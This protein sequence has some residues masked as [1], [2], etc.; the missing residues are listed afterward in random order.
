MKFSALTKRIINDNKDSS[1]KIDPWAVHNLAVQ[2]VEKGD[3]VTIL[4]IG[5]ETNETT[6]E[7]IVEAAVTSLRSGRHHY[8]DV[9]G[10]ER[11]RAAVARYHARLTGQSMGADDVTI[12]VGAQNALFAVA[13]VLLGSDDEVILVAPFYT[14][15]EA[16]FGASG[17][18]VI[19]VQVESTD[20]YQLD[21]D[22]LIAAVTPNTQAI[23]LNAP[24][25]PLGS[26]Y[27]KAQL[28]KIVKTCVDNAIWL[29]LDAVYIDIVDADSLDL[30]HHVPGAQDIL[31]TV[32]SL[33]KSHRMTGWRV[34]W[35]IGP[36]PLAEH[37]GNLSV[38]MHYGLAPFVMDAAVV[39]LEESTETPGVVRAMM[40]ARRAIA[41][42]AF[43]DLEPVRLLD[44]GQGMFVLLD[45]E[46]LGIDAYTFAMELLA[47]HD[48]SVLPC[49]GFGPGGR[50]LLRIGLCI[51]GKALSNAC[52]SIQRFIHEK[53]T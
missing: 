50:Y 7:I 23:V 17:P 34:G 48:V 27:T 47:S 26:R 36:A 25:N 2:R 11:L 15:Y 45:V 39:A 35:A 43:T 24:N 30:P 16:T 12:Y 46:P 9:R 44:A 53:R 29:I 28:E 18:K 42:A 38:C 20:S 51:D 6:P 52:N 21:E 1:R 22:K 33:S 49:D 10:D 4:S 3:P 32:G 40:Q 8:A 31:I 5:Q 37:L 41:I 19:T 14:T 13:Q